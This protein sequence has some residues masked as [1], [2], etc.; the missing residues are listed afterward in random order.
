M[1]TTETGGTKLIYNGYPGNVY[2][3]TILQDDDY[4]IITNTGNFTYDENSGYWGTFSDSSNGLEFS[5]NI[6]AYSEYIVDVLGYVNHDNYSEGTYTLLKDGNLITTKTATRWSWIT[7][8]NELGSVSANTK[9]TIRLASGGWEYFYVR[10]I[11][12]GNL[13]GTGCDNTGSDTLIKSIG[14]NTLNNSPA[15]SGYMYNKVYKYVDESPIS[16]AY[17]SG[18][19]IYAQGKY[20]LINSEVNYANQRFYTCNSTSSN[21]TCEKVRFYITANRYI[22]LSDGVNI[23]DALNEMLNNDNVNQIDSIAKEELE[24]WYYETLRNY[25]D[26]IEDTVWCNERSATELGAFSQKNGG[27]LFYNTYKRVQENSISLKCSN[28]TDRFSL[29]NRL[30]QLNYSIGLITSDEIRLAGA[31]LNTTNINF[32][33]Y[34]KA[35]FWT[36]SPASYSV[37]GLG[38]R[39]YRIVP[40][41]ALNDNDVIF[42]DGLRPVISL[43]LGTNIEKG[44]GT[45]GNPY[46]IS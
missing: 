18:S 33:L 30:A 32:Y 9:V 37:A 27:D 15:Y 11:K 4:N 38:A 19:I 24:G 42:G 29:T 17:F 3:K 34:N 13:L 36:M 40:F 44:D 16:N 10:L 1:R 23:D 46:V 7:D 45:I 2:E 22:E 12:K 26:S 14:L 20:K 35:Y 25:D 41:G 21:D 43:S 8:A 28:K 39:N 31:Q 5:F 6:P